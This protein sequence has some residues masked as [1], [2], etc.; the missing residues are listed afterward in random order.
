MTGEWSVMTG[1]VTVGNETAATRMR[2]GRPVSVSGVFN[3]T[4]SSFV[5]SGD[6]AKTE[7]CSWKSRQA[8]SEAGEWHTD[9]FMLTI[10]TPELRVDVV[11][12]MV[13]LTSH[14]TLSLPELYTCGEDC[15]GGACSKYCYTTIQSEE[16]QPGFSSLHG[17][18]G[19]RM[20]LKNAGM[21]PEGVESHTVA[22]VGAAT[23]RLVH[24]GTQGEGMIEGSYLDYVMS[25]TH[26]SVFNLHSCTPGLTTKIAVEARGTV[27]EQQDQSSMSEK[28]QKLKQIKQ[29][30]SRAE[31]SSEN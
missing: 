30:K 29:Q 7:G 22:G 16:T 21:V 18:L 27:K 20:T 28:L 9:L 4:L 23:D 31:K 2:V 12:Q 26:T 6:K 11:K 10:A 13:T 17:L 25:A 15:C 14:R 1:E 24:G 8:R 3:L 19:Q 5:C